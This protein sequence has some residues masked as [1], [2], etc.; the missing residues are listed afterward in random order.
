MAL[1]IVARLPLALDDTAD[2][3]HHS[4]PL[5]ILLAFLEAQRMAEAGPAVVSATP[6]VQPAS[7]S[8][9]CRDNFA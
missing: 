4:L 5:A 9:I 8:M 1:L 2:A 6:H 3:R 7:D